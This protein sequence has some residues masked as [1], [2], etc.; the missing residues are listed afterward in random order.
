MS[1][2][3][4][5]YSLIQGATANILDFGAD[6]TG[7]A[8]S[9]S[10]I[11]AALNTMQPVFIPQGTFKV[12]STLTLN[13]GQPKIFGSSREKSIIKSYVNGYTFIAFFTVNM[14]DFTIE[15]ST[16]IQANAVASGINMYDQTAHDWLIN[17][18]GFRYLKRAIRTSQAWIGQ[19][20]NIYVED[21]GTS[22]EYA[23]SLENSTNGVNFTN[24]QIRGDRG[25]VGPSP[26]GKWAGRG[27]FV[28]PG[29][30]PTGGA[31][32]DCYDISFNNLGLEHLGTYYAAN[33]ANFV[34][35][36]G[37]Y[38]EVHNTPNTD[39]N[40]VRF[41][42]RANII[43]GFILC[44]VEL[45]DSLTKVNWINCNLPFDYPGGNIIGGID[46]DTRAYFNLDERG[47]SLPIYCR[48]Q[49]YNSNNGLA[50]GNFANEILGATPETVSRSAAGSNSLEVVADGF[51][52]SQ[53]MKF[54]VT[55]GTTSAGGAVG[56]PF[57]FLPANQ[58]NVYAFVVA[59]CNSN[60]QVVVSL[61]GPNTEQPGKAIFTQTALGDFHVFLLGPISEPYDSRLWVRAYGAAGG[62]PANGT[63]ITID[64]WGVSF[65]GA[66][67]S[68]ITK[69]F[70]LY[71]SSFPTAGTWAQGDIAYDI[72]PTAG[73]NIGWVCTTAGTPGTWKTYGAIAA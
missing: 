50:P 16:N 49:N 25:G 46:T 4:V 48:G 41:D 53:S 37:A 27:L 44:K 22:T 60:A 24:L 55:D 68:N 57:D 29:V 62:N 6:P 18:V 71:A 65:G 5:S 26:T 23:I 13:N 56:L 36:F 35:I 33:F 43:G 45:A 51:Y 66:D 63:Q 31:V 69:S 2:T 8:D 14:D 9:T 70:N 40:V 59:K 64:S 11:Q 1:L 30:S 39:Y 10:A 67:Y 3:K 72:T 12:T 17:N 15:G 38:W 61:G 32:G 20:M 54:T 73:G 28:G 47:P 52:N 34:S 7:V 19:G 21:C 58:E 42:S